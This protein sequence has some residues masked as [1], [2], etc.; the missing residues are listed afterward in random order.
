MF[1]SWI[2]LHLFKDFN[3]GCSAAILKKNSLWLLPFYM[4]VAAHCYYEKVRRT[5]RTAI[6]SFLLKWIWNWLLDFSGL[7]SSSLLY[8]PWPSYFADFIAFLSNQSRC[9]IF[10]LIAFVTKNLRKTKSL[11]TNN[12]KCKKKQVQTNKRTL[13][14]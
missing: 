5:M 7:R 13:I 1:S 6:A 10:F 12:Q 2:F 9:L 14:L 3:D 8:G 4:V 11:N